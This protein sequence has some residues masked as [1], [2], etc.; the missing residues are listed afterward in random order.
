MILAQL[1]L[2]LVLKYLEGTLL[3]VIKPLYRIAEV[4]VYWWITYYGHHRKELDIS[5]LT[6]D[7]CLLIING[8]ADAFRLVGM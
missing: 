1:P 5:I 3:Y 8:N 7:P 6:Y 2:E 4:G